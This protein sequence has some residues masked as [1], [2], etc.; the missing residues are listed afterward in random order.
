M[1]DPPSGSFPQRHWR[2]LA[3]AAT[4]LLALTL[5]VA[6]L[7]GFRTADPSGTARPGETLEAGPFRLTLDEAVTSRRLSGVKAPD[8]RTTLVALR[9]TLAITVDEPIG[10]GTVADLLIVEGLGVTYDV[11]GDTADEVVASLR[12]P[13]GS[14]LIGVGPGL[15]YDVAWIYVVD[16]KDV[17]ATLDVT[18]QEHE[19]VVSQLD[20][21][22]R[23]LLPEPSVRLRLPVVDEPDGGGT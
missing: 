7:G 9:G 19:L 6:L 5:L 17:P 21:E 14:S 12:M 3:A 2:A 22:E 23:W 18:V 11:Y 15:T 20:S 13:D 1:P 10:T 8:R 16:S 4:A